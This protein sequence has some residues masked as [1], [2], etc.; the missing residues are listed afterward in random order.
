MMIPEPPDLAYLSA[1]RVRAVGSLLVLVAVSQFATSSPRVAAASPQPV[2]SARSSPSEVRALLDRYCV[3][4][5]NQL[6]KTAGLE[7]DRLDP[8]LVGE[9]ADTWEKVVRRLRTG[10]MPPAGSRRPDHAGYATLT[11]ALESALDTAAARAPNPGR[12]SVHRLNRAEYANA[13]RDLLGVSI[14]PRTYLPADDSG[15]G[16]DNIA[17]VLSVSPGLLDRYLVAAGRIA[18]LA[19]ADPSIRPGVARY[20]VPLLYLQEDRA[21]EDLPFGSRG[22]LAVRHHFPADGEYVVKVILQRTGG[23][24]IRGIGK[25]RRLEIRLDRARVKE[26]TFGGPGR[27]M[28][29]AQGATRAADA[30]LEVRFPAKAGTR[31][32]AASFVQEPALDEGVFQPRPPIASFAWANKIDAEPAID[33]IEIHGPYN[34]TSATDFRPWQSVFV[35]RPASAQEEGSCA[36]SILS[37]LARRAYRRPIGDSD[38][39]SLMRFYQAGREKADFDTGIAWALE[40][41]LVDPEFLF[42]IERPPANLTPGM[43]YQLSDLE[44]ASRL[45]FFLW[46]SVPDDELLRAASEGRLKD[47]R[48]LEQQ[49]ARLLADERSQALVENFAGQWLWQRNMR[50]HAPDQNIF[51]EF[52]ENLREAF[53]TETQLFLES[54]L[55]EDRPVMELLTANYTFVNERLARHYGFEGAYGSHF[56]RI[57]QPDTRRAGLL[58]QGSVLTVTSYA[59]RTSPVVRGKWLLENILGAPPPPPPANIPALRE[60]D[61]KGKPTS[62]RERLE[63]HRNNPICSSC[64]ARMDPLGFALENFDATGKWRT[65]GEGGTGI[66]ASG[67]LPDGTRFNGPAEFRA[68]LLAH[69]DEFVGTLTEKLLT[70]AIGRGVEYYDMPEVRK[71]LKSASAKENRWSALIAGV[72][73]STPFRMSVVPQQ[74][75]AVEARR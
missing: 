41:I 23:D 30:D 48:T 19:V 70:Y 54:Q 11:N 59:H 1:V 5:H 24:F 16:F 25:P 45:S 37:T 10:S 61:E 32:V 33:T 46:S 53:Q 72:V 63:E 3:T 40:R 52:D 22:G 14:D 64:H 43:P 8:G 12:P 6:L 18:R 50:T 39:A 15:Y 55:R 71:I 58:G 28:A 17:D 7:L 62:V 36:Q 21:G 29:G 66:D 26:F 60:N 51:P 74:A 68:A 27:G 13:V 9:H 75:P 65:V 67:T 34:A 56:R 42:R 44:L 38:V 20:R 73:N 35:C 69:R 4:C 2:S 49:I 57:T 47:P 31:L